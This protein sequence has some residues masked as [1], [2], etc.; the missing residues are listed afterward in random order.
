MKTSVSNMIL[1][2]ID[3]VWNGSHKIHRKPKKPRKVPSKIKTRL[4]TFFDSKRER[5]KEHIPKRICSN[6]ANSY[7]PVLLGCFKALMAKISPIRSEYRIESSW[8]L[9][10]DKASSHISLLV[11]QFLAKINVL[12][13]EPYMH[14]I[15]LF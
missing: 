9:L 5:T 15:Y 4:I 6:S 11:R 3:E 14:C 13:V 12:Y 1:K 7:R 10:D 2:K 8:C